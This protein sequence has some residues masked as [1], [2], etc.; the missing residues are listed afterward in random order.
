[1]TFDLRVAHNWEDHCRFVKGILGVTEPNVQVGLYHGVGHAILDI[2]Y[3]MKEFWPLKKALIVVTDG[4]PYLHSCIRQFVRESY[5]ITQVNS[6]DI[7]NITEWVAGLKADVLAVIYSGDHAFT[8]ELLLPQELSE[9]LSAKK[10]CSVEIQHSLHAYTKKP[11]F[12]W[13]V[14]IQHFFPDLAV[15]MQGSRVRMFQHSAPFLDWSHR[16]LESEIQNWRISQKEDAETIRKFE[17]QFFNENKWA[18]RN[19]FAAT[20]DKRLWDRSILITKG[21]GGDHLIHRLAEK[22]NIDLKSAGFSDFLETTHFCRW[23]AA[24]EWGWWGR[25]VAVTEDFQSIIAITTNI[26]ERK[27]FLNTFIEVVSAC[28]QESELL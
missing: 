9:R 12:P 22:L 5:V 14:Q 6:F 8:G 15:A 20:N 17:A 2:L 25:G 11:V 3:G 23:K 16:N 27:D 13:H 21:L 7:G 26:L 19:Y 18:I 24:N 1:M 28:H 4:D 10:I